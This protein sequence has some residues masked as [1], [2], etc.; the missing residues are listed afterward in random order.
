ME[1][2]ERIADC[3][4]FHNTYFLQKSLQTHLTISLLYDGCFCCKT[5]KN[6]IF[7]GSS[8]GVNYLATALMSFLFNR[9]F[10]NYAGENGVAAFTVINYI[11]NFTTTVMFGISDGI[12]SIVSCNYGAGKNNR[13][14]K[15]LYTAITIN[16]LLGISVLCL[17]HFHSDSLVNIFVSDN[18][19]AKEL[20]VQGA[21]IYAIGFLFNGYNI[22]MSGYHTSIGN[23][24]SSAL[25]AAGRG[26]IF[27][28]AGITIFPFFM[29][30]GGVWF[31]FP[32]AEI[33]TFVC[34]FGIW[35][36][37][38]YIIKLRSG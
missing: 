24:L 16:F 27:I 9:A 23:A 19:Q 6:I 34:C 26:I 29:G 25:I 11:G 35:A 4:Y 12:G 3:M 28:T 15:T 14:A 10:M 8:E 37:K 17:L 18:I 36:I 21:K 5:L 31:T 7:N 33:S 32:F 13:V 2:L 30:L 20:S 1:I 22:V 38:K